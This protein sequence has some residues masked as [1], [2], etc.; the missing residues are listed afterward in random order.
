MQV[1]SNP[2]IPN[3][4]PNFKAIKSVKINGMYKQYP[5]Q[6]QKLVDTFQRNENAMNFCK[7]YDVKIIFDAYRYT[8]YCVKSSIRIIIYKTKSFGKIQDLY[9]Y[10][11]SFLRDDVDKNIDIST[12]KLSEKIEKGGIIDGSLNMRE[13]YIQKILDKK[14]KDEEREKLLP[15]IEQQYSELQNALGDLIKKSK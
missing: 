12:T 3:T 9:F 2:Q 14:A 1:Q 7:K 15:P 5:K 11:N 8:R 6:A 10:A 4:I 13:A